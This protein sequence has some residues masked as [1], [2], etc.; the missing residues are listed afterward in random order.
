MP[1]E[2]IFYGSG[3]SDPKIMIVVVGGLLAV[4]FVIVVAYAIYNMMR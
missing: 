4:G 3:V 2:E 1:G